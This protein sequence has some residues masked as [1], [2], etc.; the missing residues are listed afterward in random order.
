[1][2]FGVENL[3]DED[4]TLMINMFA[5]IQTLSGPTSQ[6]SYLSIRA[7]D[8]NND[9]VINIRPGGPG[10]WLPSVFDDQGTGT[11]LITQGFAPI[12]DATP[13]VSDFG[14]VNGPDSDSLGGSTFEHL[15]ATLDLI[16]SPG[17]TVFVDAF[18]GLVEQGAPFPDI[19]DI[20]TLREVPEPS[21]GLL[22]SL[23]GLALF[24]RRRRRAKRGSAL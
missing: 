5:P 6:R 21:S 14:I 16:I 9:D 11:G 19:P 12:T 4:A 24:R 20:S 3:A 18:I 8:T 15:A 1:M 17:D 23:A 13:V 22:L 10:M 7:E 2:Q